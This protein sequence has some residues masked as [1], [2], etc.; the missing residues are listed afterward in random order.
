L[1]ASGYSP[2]AN[3]HYFGETFLDCNVPVHI[4]GARRTAPPPGQ[5]GRYRPRDGADLTEMTE[6]SH[7]AVTGARHNYGNNP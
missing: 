6:G 5:T 4:P 2:V 1:A 3:V 7:A